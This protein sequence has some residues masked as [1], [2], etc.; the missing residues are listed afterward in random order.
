MDHLKAINPVTYE[1][2]EVHLLKKYVDDV[3]VALQGVRPGVRYDKKNKILTWSTEAEEE[4][5]QKTREELTM[6]LFCELAT[7]VEKCLDFTWDLPEKNTSGMLP[8]LHR[9]GWGRSREQ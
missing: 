3:L 5:K 6:S 7:D 1:S 2:L 4:D 9:C 8:V